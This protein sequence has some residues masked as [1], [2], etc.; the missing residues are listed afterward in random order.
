[1]IDENAN[2]VIG[3]KVKLDVIIPPEN[4]T[5]STGPI[6]VEKEAEFRVVGVSSEEKTA[7]SLVPIARLEKIDA[8]KYT[9]LKVKVDNRDNVP[10]IRKQIENNGFSTE[11]IGDTVQQISQFFSFFRIILFAFGFIALVVAALG[12]FNTLTISLLERIKEVG[13]FKALGMRNRDVYKIFLTEALLIGAAGGILGLTLGIVSGQIINMVLYFL[14]DRAHVERIGI[15]ETPMV[16]ALIVAGFSLVL[17]FVTGWYP[18][19]RAVKIDP[20]D[21]LRYE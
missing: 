9:T 5:I 21:A 17:G 4:Q 6:K 10:R 12:T 11:Y 8:T 20:L 16:F 7:H 1:M 13:L 15:F 18:A 2:S 14:A 19:R 3:K